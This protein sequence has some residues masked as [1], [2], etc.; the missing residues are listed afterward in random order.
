[1]G[2]AE[3][4]ARMNEKIKVLPDDNPIKAKWKVLYANDSSDGQLVEEF[5]L[6]LSDSI[7]LAHTILVEL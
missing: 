1:M 2:I 5:K 7:E 3:E 4:I 6:Y